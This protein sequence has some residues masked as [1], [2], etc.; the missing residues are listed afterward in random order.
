MFSLS[1]KTVKNAQ[2]G[3]FFIHAA[4]MW[5]HEPLG[6]TIYIYICESLS[7]TVM[8]AHEPLGMTIYIYESLSETVMWAHEPLGM[9]IYIYIYESLSET[10]MW[11][12][13]L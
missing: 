9:T 2:R 7:E 8:W 6:M 10:V 3:L 1:L 12:H 5:A 11:A 13:D 4:V